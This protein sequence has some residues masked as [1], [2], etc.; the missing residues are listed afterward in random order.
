MDKESREGEVRRAP[1]SGRTGKDH[2]TKLDKLI[3][4]ELKVARP[5]CLV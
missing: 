4:Q 1:E 3:D 2:S 5:D